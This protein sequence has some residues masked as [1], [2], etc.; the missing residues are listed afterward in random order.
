MPN[1]CSGREVAPSLLANVGR[2][3]LS[4]T[5]AEAFNGH[6]WVRDIVEPFIVPILID[7]LK[8]W[9][10]IQNVQLTENSLDVLRWKWSADMS[11][12]S[13]LAYH[14]LFSGVVRP[15]GAKEL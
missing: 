3:Q 14:A 10:I 12:S 5:V 15:L 6:A 7:Y 1:G 11:Y 8:L 9:D 4:R 13:A 2:R